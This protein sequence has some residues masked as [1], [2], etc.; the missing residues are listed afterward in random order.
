MPTVRFALNDEYYHRLE[1]NAQNANMNIQDYIRFRLFNEITIFTVEE[2]VRRIR[3]G[4][5]EDTEFTLPDVYGDNWT[6]SREDG[7][8]ALEKHFYNYITEHPELGIHFIPDRTIKRRAVYT[9]NRR[10]D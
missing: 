3:D 2:A 10:E 4:N 6:M 7:A 5:F 1:N 8:G 9:Y